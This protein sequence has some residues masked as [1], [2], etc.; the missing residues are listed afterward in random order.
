VNNSS[1]ILA[2]VP[3]FSHAKCLHRLS[4]GVISSLFA[5]PAHEKTI[6][7][8]HSTGDFLVTGCK[9]GSI[10]VWGNGADLSLVSQFDLNNAKPR[11]YNLSVRSVSFLLDRHR[12]TVLVG[13]KSADVYEIN[14]LTGRMVQLSTAH[15]SD[16]LWGL[17]PHPSNPD[18][19]ITCG[20]DKTIRLWS[21][22]RKRQLAIVTLV[23]CTQPASADVVSSPDW[24]ALTAA[25]CAVSVVCC[26]VLCCVALL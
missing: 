10:K 20:D 7:S 19:Y 13:T 14:R 24:L 15:C 1:C 6:N 26:V 9:D 17:A 22:S 21:I 25:L 11:P 5:L 3:G 18:L 23:S 16:E 2:L 12:S 8:L 4:D